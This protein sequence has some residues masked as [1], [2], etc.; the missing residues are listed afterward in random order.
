MISGMPKN[1]RKENR[2]LSKTKTIYTPKRIDAKTQAEFDEE[3]MT[4]LQE[5][6]NIIVDMKDTVYISSL[7][8]RV[9]LGAMKEL[10]KTGGDMRVIHVTPRVMEVFDIT[11]YSGLL[12]IGDEE[13]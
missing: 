12:N 11:G 2:L 5:A 3:M 9:F 7:G 10:R 4:A 6:D 13:E 8:L 1:P